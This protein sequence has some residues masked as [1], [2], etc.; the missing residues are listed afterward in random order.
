M[1]HQG[2]RLELSAENRVE[3]LSDI[4]RVLRE[5]GLSVVRADVKTQGEK[6]VNA[7]YLKDILG[8]EVDKRYVESVKKEMDVD[9]IDFE[10]KDG[11][12]DNSVCQSSS[13]LQ[14][15]PGFFSL[16]DAL[17]SQIQRI[18]HNFIPIN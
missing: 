11:G 4:T 5:N 2:I 12:V 17:K 9:V 16:G 7:F 10:V 3:L 18:S 8:N 1:N 15:S 14:K 13:P 6:A